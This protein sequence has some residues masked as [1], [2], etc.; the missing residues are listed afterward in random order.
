MS[1]LAG[2]PIFFTHFPE[3]SFHLRG[4]KIDDDKSVFS[5]QV[6]NGSK[7]VVIKHDRWR[8]VAGRRG[9]RKKLWPIFY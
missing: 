8:V 4:F 7:K 5:L 6:E 2:M 3:I 1:V 9:G